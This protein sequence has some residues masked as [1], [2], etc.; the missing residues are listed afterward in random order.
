VLEGS[1]PK[2]GVFKQ[3]TVDV[4]NHSKKNGEGGASG[5]PTSKLAELKASLAS[6]T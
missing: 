5:S 3:F 4:P 2:T 1:N 6:G